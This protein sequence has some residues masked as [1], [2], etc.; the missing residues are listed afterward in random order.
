MI[1][2]S[3]GEFGHISIVEESSLCSCGNSGC[4]EA[5]ISTVMI[6]LI[7]IIIYWD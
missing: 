5:L 4:L 1:Y 7:L 6:L 3:A 2:Y